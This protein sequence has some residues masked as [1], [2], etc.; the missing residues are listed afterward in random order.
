MSSQ[1]VLFTNIS[2]ALTLQGVAAKDGRGVSESDL[3]LLP[4]PV[5]AV[6]DGRIAWIGEKKKFGPKERQKVFGKAK[7]R[8]VDLKGRVVMP[9]FVECHTHLIFAGD[10]K[11]EF[12]WRNQG[13]SDQEIS[14]RGGGIRTTVEH[15]RAASAPELRRLGQARVDRFL[16]Q[17]VTLL[18]IKSGYGL[19]LESEL[20]ILKAARM[21]RG[22]EIVTTFLGPHAVAPEFKN[23]SD[24]LEFLQHNILPRV[25]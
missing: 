20:K 7:P 13:A 24:Y 4:K 2:E 21:L 25:A 11:V 17:G 12:E 1:K 16:K 14:A 8:E 23:T 5:I 18:E 15:T 3:G 22:P 9:G 6:V 19:D 10:R